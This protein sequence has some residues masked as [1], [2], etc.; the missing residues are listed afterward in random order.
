MSNFKPFNRHILIEIIEEEEE[1]DTKPFLLPDDYKKPESPYKVC[2]VSL[3]SYDSK[4]A[5][6]LKSGDMIIV[7]QR[8]LQKIDVDNN[9]FYLILENYVLGRITYEA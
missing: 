6:S 4:F 5:N 7:E 8:M 9:E 3:V 2:E 1:K